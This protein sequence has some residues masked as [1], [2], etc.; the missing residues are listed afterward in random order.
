[1]KRMLTLRETS[2]MKLKSK[3]I[4]ETAKDGMSLD[5]DDRLT[6]V[7]E[8]SERTREEGKSKEKGEWAMENISKKSQR[9]AK[10]ITDI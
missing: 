10:P 8:R 5:V 9:S 1:M 2:E 6:E 3:G 4:I 7:S